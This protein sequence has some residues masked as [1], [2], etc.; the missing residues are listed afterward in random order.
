[1]NRLSK[2]QTAKKQCFSLNHLVAAQKIFNTYINSFGSKVCSRDIAILIATSLQGSKICKKTILNNLRR[3]KYWLHTSLHIIHENI[4]LL[5]PNFP[6]QVILDNCHLLLYPVLDIEKHINYLQKMRNS[7]SKTRE[8]FRTEMDTYH[9]NL[10][11]SKLTDSQILSLTLYEIEKKYHYSGD[12]IWNKQDGAREEKQ[13]KK[14][15]QILA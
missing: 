10:N 11:Y 9:N 4:C 2:L 8:K 6:D 12:G 7:D 1:M 5:K 13:M 15:Q 14:S 3:H